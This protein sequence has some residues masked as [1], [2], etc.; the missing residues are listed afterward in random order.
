MYGSACG[1]V[2]HYKYYS[3]L[4]HLLPPMYD[5]MIDLFPSSLEFNNE[6]SISIRSA[7]SK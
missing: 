4:P 6:F 2:R 7:P 5:F 1:C 3:T